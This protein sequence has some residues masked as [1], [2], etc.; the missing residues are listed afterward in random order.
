MKKY[1][2]E[3]KISSY[4]L[5]I[6]SYFFIFLH[7][8]FIFLSYYFFIIPFIFLHIISFIFIYIAEPIVRPELGIFLFLSPV[9]EGGGRGATRKIQIYPRVKISEGGSH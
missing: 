6:S 2:G 8:S 7:I 3:M 4:F 9:D 5:H 1:E